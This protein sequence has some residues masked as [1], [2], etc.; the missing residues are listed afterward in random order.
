MKTQLTGRFVNSEVRA[1]TTFHRVP[2]SA[3]RDDDDKHD[4]CIS[5]PSPQLP[6][7]DVSLFFPPLFH[8]VPRGRKNPSL[9]RPPGS[10]GRGYSVGLFLV[11]SIPIRPLPN[12]RNQTLAASSN[13]GRLVL[14]ARP[15]KFP[16]LTT[17]S[18]SSLC[19]P[20]RPPRSRLPGASPRLSAGTP[21][22]VYSFFGPAP[23]LSCGSSIR[24]FEMG[25]M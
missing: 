11:S 22:C 19:S 23:R 8:Q 6:S 18:P 16:S 7:S 1:L 21:A 15:P 4:G 9:F 3:R 17:F 24:S 20:L 2:I 5:S 12:H 13:A 25:T 10:A 14:S